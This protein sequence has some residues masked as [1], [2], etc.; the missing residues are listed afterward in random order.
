MSALRPTP[1]ARR[2]LEEGEEAKLSAKAYD[3]GVGGGTY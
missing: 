3:A 1:S 2:G